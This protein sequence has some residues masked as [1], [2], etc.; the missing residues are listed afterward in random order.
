MLSNTVDYKKISIHAASHIQN[1]KD[2][3]NWREVD[4]LIKRQQTPEEFVESMI[5]KSENNMEGKTQSLSNF[6]KLKKVGKCN[7]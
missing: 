2:D 4:K 7:A 3:T 5:R 1:A 6:S